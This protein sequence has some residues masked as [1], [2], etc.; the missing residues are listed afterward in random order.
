MR[1]FRA[2]LFDF[3]DTLARIEVGSVVSGRQQTAELCGIVDVDRFQAG[4]RL[5]AQAR[6]LGTAG[7]L[8]EQIA[9]MLSDMGVD[10]DEA[11]VR[12][13][14][15]ADRHAWI[16]GVRV[17]EDSALTL[18]ALTQRGFRLGLV[19]NCSCQGGDVLQAKGLRPHFTAVAFSFELGTAKPEP[20]IFL[21]A[22]EQLGMPP[23][24]CLYIA[25]GAGG[26]LE[27]AR[28]LGMS[29]V[30]VEHEDQH[31]REPAPSEYDVRVTRLREV[32]DLAELQQ[33]R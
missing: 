10:S 31:R 29:T 2:V 8:E 11:L 25:D 24:D 15:E 5:N 13:L 17:Y 12:R 26:E 23:G 9:T 3:Y 7:S 28:G 20:E 21:A 22:C 19:S 16:Q 30:L 32:L 4:W 6:M 27:A 18:E 14:A 33:P 1:R